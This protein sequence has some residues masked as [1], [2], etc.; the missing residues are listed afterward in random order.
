MGGTLIVNGF[1]MDRHKRVDI[2]AMW[3]LH[4]L[5]S[6]QETLNGNVL[7]PTINPGQWNP[8]MGRIP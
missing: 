3:H 2:E 4:G 5:S 6:L 1:L 7:Y 8:K